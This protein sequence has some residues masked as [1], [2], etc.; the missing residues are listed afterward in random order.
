MPALGVPGLVLG[1][2]I[3]GTPIWPKGGEEFKPSGNDAG[4]GGE[5]PTDTA[6]LAPPISGFERNK[7]GLN[8]S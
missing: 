8:G 1:D 5:V 2:D 3:L 6:G 4:T 7:A